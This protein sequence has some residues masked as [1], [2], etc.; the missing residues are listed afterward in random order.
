MP[1]YGSKMLVLTKTEP[2]VHFQPCLD[3]SYSFSLLFSGLLSMS[4]FFILYFIYIFWHT[5]LLSIDA[6]LS[7][8]DWSCLCCLSS[9]ML[10][11]QYN[12]CYCVFQQCQC[13][14]ILGH[15]NTVRGAALMS[16]WMSTS[17]YIWGIKDIETMQE[18]I[19]ICNCKLVSYLSKRLTDW[20]SGDWKCFWLRFLLLLMVASSGKSHWMFF[21]CDSVSSLIDTVCR[22]GLLVAK[23]WQRNHCQFNDICCSSCVLLTDIWRLMSGI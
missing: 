14:C 18:K 15:Q 2:L 10:H 16:R 17:L 5:F 7:S 9:T 11:Y 4:D 8:S 22:S 23:R 1:H 21:G 19:A 6:C 20:L 12:N 3:F 13:P